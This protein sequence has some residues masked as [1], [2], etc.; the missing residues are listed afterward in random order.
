M[1]A[2]QIED[3]LSAATAIRRTRASLAEIEARTEWDH[4]CPHC[5]CSRRQKWGQTRTG[6]QRYRCTDWLR[7]YSG[8]TGSVICGFYQHD[9]FP[10]ARSR[11]S[12][13]CKFPDS[14]RA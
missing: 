8:L 5:D 3:L 13:W 14:L 12:S 1:T 4:Q 9:L 7:S 10:A 2:S 11:P 6:V